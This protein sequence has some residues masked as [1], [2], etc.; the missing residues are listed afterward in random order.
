MY[1]LAPFQR[2]MVPCRLEVP[3]PPGPPVAF[4]LALMRTSVSSWLTV[5]TA[6]M[7]PFVREYGC[8]LLAGLAI[9]PG[10]ESW[11]IT[12][13]WNGFAVFGCTVHAAVSLGNEV[14]GVELSRFKG[15]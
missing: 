3:P 2:S 15:T 5:R 13:P 11:K 6:A 1:S 7:V 12:R 9:T 8:S 14:R 10:T 4:T